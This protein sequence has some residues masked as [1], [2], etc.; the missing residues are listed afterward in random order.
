[1]NLP[2]DS[3]LDFLCC[4]STFISSVFKEFEQYGFLLYLL[5]FLFVLEIYY[6]VKCKM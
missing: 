6:F 4:L 1:M 3:D 5:L 2:L